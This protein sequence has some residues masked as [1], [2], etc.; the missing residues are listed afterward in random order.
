MTTTVRKKS[1]CSRNNFVCHLE[2]KQNV[3]L[4]QIRTRVRASCYYNPNKIIVART[5]YYSSDNKF[6]SHLE[7]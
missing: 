3:V 1:H 6:T 2:Q 4:E 7:Q 5:T